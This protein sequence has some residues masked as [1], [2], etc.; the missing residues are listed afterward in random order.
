MVRGP[1]PWEQPTEEFM[2]QREELDARKE[3][4]SMKL[5]ACYVEEGRRR[6]RRRRGESVK[7]RICQVVST[8]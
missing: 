3:T 6:E 4:L 1:R 8:A 7:G 5:N 2:K